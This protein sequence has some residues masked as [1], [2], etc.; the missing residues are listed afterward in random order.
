MAFA[1]RFALAIGFA[2]FSLVASFAGLA[3]V[4]PCQAAFIALAA[5]F[6]RKIL[7]E[8]IFSFRLARLG[9]RV[10]RLALTTPRPR[11]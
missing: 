6:A 4:V 8:P 5:I 7:P 2:A 3:A 1:A 9:N 11:F 10:V